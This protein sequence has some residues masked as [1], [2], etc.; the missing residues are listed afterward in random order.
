MAPWTMSRDPTCQM[1]TAKPCPHHHHHNTKT[2]LPLSQHS[3]FLIGPHTPATLGC[4]PGRYI[5]GSIQIKFYKKFNIYL[6][7][8]NQIYR[9]DFIRIFNNSD[10]ITKIDYSLT[11]KIGAVNPNCLFNSLSNR[12][13]I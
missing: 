5:L 9:E 8:S 7:N 3:V 6:S 11:N 12:T 13:S 10:F 1:L 2:L 4:W